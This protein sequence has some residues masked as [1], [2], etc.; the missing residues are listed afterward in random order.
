MA[1]TFDPGLTQ[2]YNGALKRAINQ[3]GEFNVRRAGLTWRDFHPYL[4]MINVSWPVFIGIIVLV[5]VLANALF[6]WIYLTIGIEHLKGAEAPSLWSQYWNAFFFSAH[7]LTT[8]GYG[9]IYP[10]GPAA[11]SVATTEA[12]L[13]LLAF[14]IATGLVFGRFSR[15]SARIGFSKTMLVAPYQG[16][17]S[18][19]FRIV[20]RRS[21]N[22]LDLDAR[23][24]L[25]TVESTEGRLQRKFL[26]LELERPHVLFFPLTWTVVHPIT[27]NSPLYGK[28]AEDLEQLQAE[29]LILIRAFDDTFGQTVQVRSS[30]RYDEIVWGAK[31]APA[32]EVESS[33]DLRLEVNKVGVFERV[34]LEDARALT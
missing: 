17:R 20:N 7:T 14:A 9:N 2:Q 19:Q 11:N 6:G 1:I 32:F 33:G 15:P 8:V 4:Y 23:L 28:T 27:E 26:D 29:V 13:G 12:L 22:L 10:S 34:P 3:D 31:F 30:Y 24:L 5:F 16:G 18:L 21:N 25:M